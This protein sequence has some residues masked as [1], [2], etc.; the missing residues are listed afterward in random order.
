MDDDPAGDADDDGAN[1]TGQ[2]RS[3]YY[4]PSYA[5]RVM[6][7]PAVI[8]IFVLRVV[9]AAACRHSAAVRPSHRPSASPQ[10]LALIA[11]GCTAS[12]VYPVFLMITR[13]TS[14]LPVLFGVALNSTMV[15]LGAGAVALLVLE[16]LPARVAR[17]PVSHALHVALFGTAHHRYGIDQMDRRSDVCSLVCD[18]SMCG[19]LLCADTVQGAALRNL[20][21]H[22]GHLSPRLNQPWPAKA[23]K[24]CGAMS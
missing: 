17:T 15:A 7:L 20:K 12:L 11:S 24:S 8:G 1:H 5:T 4:M 19:E 14:A 23:R 22:H 9:C 18:A 6:H 13:R 10:A 2:T 16:A 3:S 21:H